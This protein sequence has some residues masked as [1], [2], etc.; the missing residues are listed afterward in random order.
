M[1]EL[2]K[3]AWDFVVLRDQAKKGRLNWRVW[4]YGFGFVIVQYCIGLPAVLLYEKH[5]QY[6]PVFIFAMALIVINF[7]AFM[8]WAVRWQSRQAASTSGTQQT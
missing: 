6:K 7:I 3:L 2:F 5:P 4:I 1:F 8:W